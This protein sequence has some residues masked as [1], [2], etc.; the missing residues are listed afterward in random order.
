LLL[1]L[2]QIQDEA[3]EQSKLEIALLQH[4]LLEEQ[5]RQFEAKILLQ[6]SVAERKEECEAAK[7][8]FDDHLLM[9]A[10]LEQE[11]T[12]LEEFQKA[13]KAFNT[14]QTLQTREQ[15]ALHTLH[16]PDPNLQED[17]QAYAR[18][19]ARP[20]DERNR[21]HNSTHH[22]LFPGRCKEESALHQVSHQDTSAIIMSKEK[23]NISLSELVSSAEDTIKRV[24]A[25]AEQLK[26]IQ[27]CRQPAAAE[28]QRERAREEDRRRQE[29]EERLAKEEEERRQIEEE[30]RR[31]M[32]RI[33]Q[34]STK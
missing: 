23:T 4:Q 2:L 3:A 19:M 22:E 29:D 18:E 15:Q 12:H 5:Q 9:Y 7:R 28:R 8:D 30:E 21:Y 16:Q 1:V 26:V 10:H 17:N 20:L 13:L 6:A 34:K 25:Q 14:L 33:S 24:H 27:I 11:H 31:Q 32:A